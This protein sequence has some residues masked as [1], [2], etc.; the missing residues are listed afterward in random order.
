MTA[1]ATIGRLARVGAVAGLLVLLGDRLLAYRAAASGLQLALGQESERRWLLREAAVLETRAAAATAMLREHRGFL[2]VESDVGAGA[3]LAT[4]I[5][6]LLEDVASDQPTY[7]VNNA[8]ASGGRRVSVTVAFTSD[9]EGLID[10]LSG[11]HAAAEALCL[12][13]LAVT[14]ARGTDQVVTLAISATISAT[15]EGRGT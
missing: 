1:G 4:R 2:L 5:G 8:R 14:A 13:E 11:L 6:Q 3:A 15:Y 12:D 7:R 10:F 9:E